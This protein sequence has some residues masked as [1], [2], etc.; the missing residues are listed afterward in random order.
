LALIPPAL[1]GLSA[2]AN[3]RTQPRVATTQETTPAG[4]LPPVRLNEQQG[5]SLLHT[6]VLLQYKLPAEPSALRVYVWR[7]LKRLGA[8]LIHDAIWVLPQTPRTQE[9][10]QWLAAEIVEM[11]GDALLWQAQL[12]SIDSDETLMEQ[13]TA[14]VDSEYGEL[15]AELRS[16][17]ADVDLTALARRYQQVKQEDYFQSPLGKRV[18]DTLIGAREHREKREE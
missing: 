1:V 15:L 4:N 16:H 12:T 14:Q 7:K 13:F 2:Q 10:F 6:W 17:G 18:R 8:I 5:N 3:P 9:H 11:G